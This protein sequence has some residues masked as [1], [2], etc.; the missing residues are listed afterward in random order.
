MTVRDGYMDFKGL[1]TYYRVVGEPSDKPPLVLLHGGP[2]CSHN[3]MEVLDRLAVEDGR[4][5]VMYDQIGCGKSQAEGHKELFNLVTWVE[6]LDALRAHLGLDR[7]HLLGHSAGGMI[8]LEHACT[9]HPQGVCSYILSSSLPSSR[10][11]G[12]EQHRLIGYLPADMQAAIAHADET[13]EYEGDAFAAAEE[14]FMAR[15]CGP[16][17]TEDS[18]ECVKN[19]GWDSGLEAYMEAWG[20]NEFTPLGNMVDFDHVADLP[21]IS[22][23]VLLT[24]GGNDMSTPLLNKTMFDLL[25]TCRWELFPTARHTIYVEET[26]AYVAV[27]KSWLDEHDA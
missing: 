10:L 21:G 19:N 16:D 25:P 6:E 23:P 7:V 14:E 3:D 24:S 11:W 22:E 17:I 1:K 18:P 8:L 20:P 13:G 4:Q 26:D 9:A 27:L 5:L 2:G 15:H 12:D